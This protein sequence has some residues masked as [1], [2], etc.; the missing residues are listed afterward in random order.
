MKKINFNDIPLTLTGYEEQT[1]GLNNMIEKIRKKSKITSMILLFTGTA[2]MLT[3]IFLNIYISPGEIKFNKTLLIMLLLGIFMMLMSQAPISRFEVTEYDLN[4]M[5]KN[6]QS[7]KYWK[8]KLDAESFRR[9]ADS[10]RK[11][12]IDEYVRYY[13]SLAEFHEEKARDILNKNN[14]K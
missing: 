8:E 11:S 10:Y 12:G 7:S 6:S 4:N 13:E 5:F 2:V 9:I 3:S 1:R 14:N